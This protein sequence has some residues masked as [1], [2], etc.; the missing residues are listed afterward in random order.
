ME[1]VW[2]CGIVTFLTFAGILH[3]R[4]QAYKCLHTR[5][6]TFKIKA[7][8]HSYGNH[9]SVNVNEILNTNCFQDLVF[10]PEFLPRTDL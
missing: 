3:S 8:C 4:V 10:L 6:H 9:S 1:K 7:Q 2:L 5:I